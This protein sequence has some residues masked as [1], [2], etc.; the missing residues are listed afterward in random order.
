MGCKSLEQIIIPDRV[1]EIVNMTFNDCES[2]KE[3][4]VL[5]EPSYMTMATRLN[6]DEMFKNCHEDLTIY[7]PINNGGIVEDDPEAGAKNGVTMYIEWFG[8]Q[9]YADII[10]AMPDTWEY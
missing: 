9:T 4:Y 2:L 10:E 5:R 6:S 3:V 7:V 8:W 1:L